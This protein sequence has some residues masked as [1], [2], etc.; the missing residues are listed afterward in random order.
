MG[1]SDFK[2]ASL[3]STHSD[4][5]MTYTFQCASSLGSSH[6]GQKPE[7]HCKEFCVIL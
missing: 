3:L 6:S 1:K 2:I 7:V 5:V 4:L